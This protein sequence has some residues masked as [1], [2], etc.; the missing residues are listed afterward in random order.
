MTL[1]SAAGSD[2]DA[3]QPDGDPSTAARPREG[4]A[5]TLTRTVRR[6]SSRIPRTTM[7]LLPVCFLYLYGITWEILAAHYGGG[8][9]DNRIFVGVGQGA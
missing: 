2:G 5:K 4:L 7:I 9:F 8:G 1:I 6:Y 3:R